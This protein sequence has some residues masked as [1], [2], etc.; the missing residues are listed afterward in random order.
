MDFDTKSN[1]S[2][3]NRNQILQFYR[4]PPTDTISL[5]EFEE[6]AVER[7]KGLYELSQH[8]DWLYFGTRTLIIATLFSL[9]SVQ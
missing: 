8:S 6:Y 4:T 9:M 3:Q 2:K 5:Y 1:K 7:L